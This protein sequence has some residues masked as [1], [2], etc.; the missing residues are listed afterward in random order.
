MADGL[1]TLDERGYITSWNRAMER[2]SGYRADEAIGNGCKL[3]Q[4]SQ[5]FG[6]HCPTNMETC[7]VLKYGDAEA[8]ECHVSIN[9]L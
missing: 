4:C 6:E 3:L 5:C 2:I 8:K 7:G 9:G 1:F